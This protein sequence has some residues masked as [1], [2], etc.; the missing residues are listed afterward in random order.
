[1]ATLSDSTSNSPRSSTLLEMPRSFH[2]PNL[3]PQ[4]L[5][6]PQPKALDAENSAL[7]VGA[8]GAFYTLW[9]PN[10]GMH[11]VVSL[12]DVDDGMASKLKACR[13]WA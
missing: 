3:I 2:L 6:A 12:I 8:H 9:W 1:M 7:G 4:K 11:P 10:L 13:C 5:A